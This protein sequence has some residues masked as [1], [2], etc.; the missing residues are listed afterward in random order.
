MTEN[1]SY[2][3]KCR[4][5][6]V[7]TAKY[8]FMLSNGALQEKGFCAVCG[9]KKAKF[10]SRS[11]AN[12]KVGSNITL[13]WSKY[14]GEAHLPGYNFCGPGTRLDLRLDENNN[15]RL[16]SMPVNK[17]DEQ[18]L[19]HD[20]AYAETKDKRRRQKADI[21]LIHNLI[22]L[23]D[24]TIGEKVGRTLVKNAMKGKIVIGKGLSDE[25]KL[26]I[27][28]YSPKGYFL[29]KNLSMHYGRY[30]TPSQLKLHAQ[31]LPLRYLM[32]CTRLICYTFHMT[33]LERNGTSMH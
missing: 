22:N 30:T 6:T 26:E 8:I 21:D 2:C 9:G 4:E 23:E 29:G 12:S 25:R 18:C 33:V 24:L 7:T 1:I 10:V 17:V 13:P 3:V 14:S 16:D 27:V 28:Y 19:E 20:K 32:R 11:D 31:S 15:P 5:K